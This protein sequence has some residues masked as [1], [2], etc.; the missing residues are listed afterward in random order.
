MHCSCVTKL[1][2]G[3]HR[4]QGRCHCVSRVHRQQDKGNGAP[5]GPVVYWSLTAWFTAMLADPR[6]SPGMVKTIE[7]ARRGATE[8]T[9]GL[10]DWYDG[11][12]FRN[13]VA[14]GLF[15]NNTSVALEHRD[16]PI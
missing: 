14:K 5:A 3:F 9:P 12:T 15:Q 4:P 7:E 13:A 11:S 10:R 8:P 2:R 16:A 6:L 1:V